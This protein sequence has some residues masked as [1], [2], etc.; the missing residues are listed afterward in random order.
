MTT[1]LIYL[2][3]QSNNDM[4]WKLLSDYRYLSMY[5]IHSLY[6]AVLKK[7]LNLLV[8]EELFDGAAV[9]F[10]EPGVVKA[11]AEAQ[12]QFEVR[13]AH[14]L[15]QLLHLVLGKA[16]ELARVLLHGLS[17]N[18]RWEPSL[19]R[20]ARPLIFGDGRNGYARLSVRVAS[21][22]LPSVNRLIRLWIRYVYLGP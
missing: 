21:F 9:F 1:F 2:K 17:S 4:V 6:V 14:A 18:P 5:C 15:R 20:I 8:D 3:T 16:H 7:N 12:R 19:D 22:R 11:D 13:I 10:G